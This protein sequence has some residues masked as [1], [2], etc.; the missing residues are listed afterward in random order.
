MFKRQEDRPVQQDLQHYERF[1]PETLI[2]LH[3]PFVYYV[4]LTNFCLE[5][6]GIL[7]EIQQLGTSQTRNLAPAAS[8]RN[9]SGRKE[10]G[11]L[12]D[13]PAH[14]VSPFLIDNCEG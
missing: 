1:W 10:H 3:A 11:S 8:E 13:T 14:R 6:P 12:F 7:S 4:L 2:A 9:W 5:T